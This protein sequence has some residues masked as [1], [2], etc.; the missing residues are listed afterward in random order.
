MAAFEFTLSLVSLESKC[1]SEWSAWREQCDVI[2]PA[3]PTPQHDFDPWTH[4]NCYE[5]LLRAHS[6]SHVSLS[7]SP[8]LYPRVCVSV[9]ECVFTITCT[10]QF[11]SLSVSLLPCLCLPISLHVSL[12]SPPLLLLLSP[13]SDPSSLS[14]YLL[15]SLFLPEPH[16]E[17]S[18]VPHSPAHSAH[19][20]NSHL[21]SLPS[22]F[23]AV[24]HSKQNVRKQKLMSF[25]KRG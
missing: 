1:C 3:L 25:F 13:P 21:L 7:L 19:I 5:Y 20:L 17:L 11:L 6:T 24:G 15:P 12:V 2:D 16:P 4:L 14:S 9:F 8:P 10:H 18:G 23:L 22:P